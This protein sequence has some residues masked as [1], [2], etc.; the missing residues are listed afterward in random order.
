MAVSGT[1][2]IDQA[3]MLGGRDGIVAQRGPSTWGANYVFHSGGIQEDILVI[4]NVLANLSS[5]GAYATDAE[6]AAVSGA[7]TDGGDFSAITI[8]TAASGAAP[9]G[10]V[11]APISGIFI[12][13]VD[14][15]VMQLVVYSN[16]LVSGVVA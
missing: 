16:G 8:A 3:L 4:S 11:A 2:I 10:T 15:T 14:G 5:S 13:S 6:L 9:I 7:I 1:M 12:D